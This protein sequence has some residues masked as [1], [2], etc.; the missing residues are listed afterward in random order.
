MS[1]DVEVSHYVLFDER[2]G[3]V[4]V[5]GDHLSGFFVDVADELPKVIFRGVRE[6]NEIKART[7]D[8]TLEIFDCRRVKVGEYF[9]GHVVRGGVER[10]SVGGVVVTSVAFRSFGGRCEYV[11]AE[12]IWRHWVSDAAPKAGEWLR[13]PVDRQ[14][15][16]LHVVQNSW[17]ASGRRAGRYGTN[18]DLLLDGSEMRTRAGFY[19]ALGEAANGPRGYFGSNLDAV[20][21]CLSFTYGG[22]RL[23]RVCWRNFTDSEILLGRSFVKSVVSLFLEFGIEVNV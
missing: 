17:F 23:S 8:G 14:E 10:T 11:G 4:L 3:E 7:E 2:T 9:V 18:E 21:D 1:N 5:A 20:A 13:W 6:I 19:C 15:D 16:W 12:E 22:A